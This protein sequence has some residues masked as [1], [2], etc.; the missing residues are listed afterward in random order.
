M[1]EESEKR[2]VAE[3]I[4]LEEEEEEEEEEWEMELDLEERRGEEGLGR[5]RER[6][7]G[8]W[9]KGGLMMHAWR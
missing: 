8:G 2:K 6:R 1:R 9:K 7:P 4:L 5:G 3:E